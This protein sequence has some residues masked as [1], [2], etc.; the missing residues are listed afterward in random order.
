MLHKDFEKSSVKS[1]DDYKESMVLFEVISYPYTEAL[2]N[3]L[4]YSKASDT[5]YFVLTGSAGNGKTNLLCSISELLINLKEAVVF[6]N[7]RDI[8]GDIWEFICYQLNLPLKRV[9]KNIVV[10]PKS[11][12]YN[13]LINDKI[14]SR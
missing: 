4:Q 9:R 12:C 1:D 14:F 13:K 11:A 3:L 2:E 5:K 10:D 7:S 8:H 6:L